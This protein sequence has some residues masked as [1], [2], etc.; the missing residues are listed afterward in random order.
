M[1]CAGH[2]DP[3]LLSRE[4]KA[5]RV[6]L[7]GGP[8]FSIVDYPYPTETLTLSAGETLVLITDGVTEAQNSQGSL[9]G[10]A[11]LLAGDAFSAGDAGAI[12]QAIR[13]QVRAFEDGVEAT[14]DLTVMAVRYLG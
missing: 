12:C 5:R 13:Q 1:T 11:R 3:I 7:E 6:R 14:D 9:F 10:S 2:D 4:G 8:P